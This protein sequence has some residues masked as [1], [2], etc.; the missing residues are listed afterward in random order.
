M[1]TN[2]MAVLSSKCI[3]FDPFFHHRGS[4]SI[5]HSSQTLHKFNVYTHL[6]TKSHDE[7]LISFIQIF[8]LYTNALAQKSSS[9]QSIN[10]M[11]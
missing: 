6:R 10:E 2:N 3:H 8:S 1:A 4:V 5:A 9:S 7:S 11:D